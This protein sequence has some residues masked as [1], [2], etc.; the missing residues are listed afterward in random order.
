MSAG[1]GDGDGGSP[2]YPSPSPPCTFPPQMQAEPGH[3]LLLRHHHRAQQRCH[4]PPAPHL[5]G[6]GLWGAP[7]PPP[8]AP[9]PP[10]PWC[11]WSP[12]GA[13]G[14]PPAGFVLQKLP[15]KFKNLF[16]KFE[17]LT[18]RGARALRG[19]WG[20][21]RAP[22]G[23]FGELVDVPTLSRGVLAH[24]PTQATSNGHSTV[25]MAASGVGWSRVGWAGC[26]H[27]WGATPPALTP[28]SPPGPLQ[29]PQDL[30]G[31]A[32]QDE[33]PS[34]PLRATHPQR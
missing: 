16:R 25:P 9:R 10:F 26:R 13:H 7:V 30:P 15:G 29:E 19:C 1:M 24:P 2:A 8:G 32:G 4:Q 11:S 22:H 27:P 12:L 17:N 20:S 14:L 21:P 31:G 5:G 33:T 6:E 3:A 23:V 28:H 34:H 18:V